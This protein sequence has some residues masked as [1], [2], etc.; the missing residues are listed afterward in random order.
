MLPVK[1]WVEAKGPSFGFKIEPGGTS[2]CDPPE[3]R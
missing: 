1:P 3:R 2:L